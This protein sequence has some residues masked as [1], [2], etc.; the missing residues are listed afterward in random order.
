[1]WHWAPEE[2]DFMN[3]MIQKGYRWVNREENEN[4]L[5]LYRSPVAILCM[6]EWT[7]AEEE[8]AC[9]ELQGDFYRTCYL[10]NM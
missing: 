4:V 5:K 8:D 10:A 7:G 2:I 9:Q 6:G 1:M 3:R